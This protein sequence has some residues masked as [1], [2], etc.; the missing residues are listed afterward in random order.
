[1]TSIAA[2][3]IVN[4]IMLLFSKSEIPEGR[5]NREEKSAME[6]LK[7]Y[8]G[9][10]ISLDNIKDAENLKAFGFACRYLPDPPED[11]D[12]FEFVTDFEGMNNLGLMVTVEMAKIKKIF[13]GLFS[14]DDPDIVSALTEDQLKNFLDQR[15]DT[16][17]RFFDYITQ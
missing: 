1:M 8:I 13:F 3:S 4:N 6:R 7:R 15:G 10:K 2:L 5:P 17:I 14:P 16:L 9:S 12:E 11:F